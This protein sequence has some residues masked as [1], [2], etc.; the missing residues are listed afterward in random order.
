MNSS[1]VTG[2]IPSSIMVPPRRF[3]TLLHQA[4]SYQRHHCLYHNSPTSAFSLYSDHQ[5]DKSAFPR[6][7]TII[8]DGH[9]DE[10]WNVEWSH[11]GRYLATASKDKSAIIW[12][13]QVSRRFHFLWCPLY[14]GCLCSAEPMRTSGNRVLPWG[15]TLILWA[16][17]LGLWMIRYC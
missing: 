10:V 9:K 5:C 13:F 7:T 1:Y 16:A 4:R 3:S 8:L 15:T 17:W 12:G 14:A 11:S 2:Y 6:V